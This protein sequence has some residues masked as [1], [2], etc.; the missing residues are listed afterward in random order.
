MYRLFLCLVTLAARACQERIGLTPTQDK[1]LQQI[2]LKKAILMHD[3]YAAEEALRYGADPNDEHDE[4]LH[5]AAYGGATSLVEVL[6]AHGA[7]VNKHDSRQHTAVLYAIWHGYIDIVKMLIRAGATVSECK[8]AASGTYL[9]EAVRHN[10]HE[11]MRELIVAYPDALCKGDSYQENPLHCAVRLISGPYYNATARD[12]QKEEI[13][14]RT[15]TQ[16][17]FYAHHYNVLP[18]ML[19]QKNRGQQTVQDLARALGA[20]QA[21]ITLLDGCEHARPSALNALHDI[22]TQFEYEAFTKELC[23]KKVSLSTALIQREI[24]GKLR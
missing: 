7:E 16:L 13:K 24:T 9:H 8:S 11:V 23:R 20:Q 3:Y 17:L 14:E 21:T 6:L 4:P 1:V 22:G 2:A 15:L 18:S 19:Q 5:V 10:A 12:K